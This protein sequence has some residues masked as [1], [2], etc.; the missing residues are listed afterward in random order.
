MK[1]SAGVTILFQFHLLGCHEYLASDRPHR[2][3][4]H[5]KCP[6]V[7][8]FYVEP[9]TVLHVLFEF[10]LYDKEIQCL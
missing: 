3:L 1:L 2:H 5:G 4:L 8:T 10:K 7:H 6:P 9:L